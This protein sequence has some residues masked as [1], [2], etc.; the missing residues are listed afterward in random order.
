LEQD[1]SL[2]S[3]ETLSQKNNRTE[4][5]VTSFRG[6]VVV[7]GVVLKQNFSFCL[8]HPLCYPFLRE[9]TSPFGKCPM[10][11]QWVEERKYSA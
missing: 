1:S 7:T 11:E 3:K 4:K 5:P 8:P 6:F 10:N 2:E 9:L